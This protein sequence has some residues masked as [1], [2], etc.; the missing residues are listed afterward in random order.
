M[1]RIERWKKIFTPQKEK[2]PVKVGDE[3]ADMTRT[4]AYRFDELSKS[5]DKSEQ[6]ASPERKDG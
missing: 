2:V 4:Q 3:L 5:P 6:P 1:S